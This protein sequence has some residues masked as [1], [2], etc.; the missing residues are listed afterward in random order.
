MARK[1]TSATRTVSTT[2][3]LAQ[4][5]TRTE[6]YL[7]KIAGIIES[8]PE[9]PFTR[10]ER[11]LELIA[12][13]TSEI[14]DKVP[15]VGKGKQLLDNGYFIGGG[16]QQGERQLPIN[17]NGDVSYNAVGICV[18][19][20]RIASLNLAVAVNSDGVKLTA[21]GNAG[22]IG[23][24]LRDTDWW[25]GKTVTLSMLYNGTKLV[26]KSMTIPATRPSASGAVLYQAF[27]S[28]GSI[29]L[30]YDVAPGDAFRVYLVASPNASYTINAVKLEL[31]DIQT[32]AHQVN[33]AWVLNDIPPDFQ[34]E[35]NK[36]KAYQVVWKNSSGNV[37]FIGSGFVGTSTVARI[38]IPVGV[39]MKA[40]PELKSLGSTGYTADD[41][42]L[43]VDNRMVP[44]K[45]FDSLWRRD[46]DG[47]Y[48][49]ANVDSSANLTANSIALLRVNT[50]AAIIASTE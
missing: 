8:A 42:S 48:V 9:A 21:G 49:N 3:D 32:L 46:V 6:R 33:G 41:C 34:T 40:Q 45:S 13:K 27:E 18:D 23:Q 43:V 36:C 37:S 15:I 20:W 38:K 30:Y 2:A 11:Y 31:G 12:G 35:L 14:D 22:S 16:S 10:L 5:Q 50:G 26:T 17:Q 47:F 28:I 1:K 44:V 29:Q 4:P 7:A 19:R 24:L 25:L 39:Y